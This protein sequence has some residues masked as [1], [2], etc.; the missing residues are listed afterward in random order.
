VRRRRPVEFE[1]FPAALPS[2]ATRNLKVSANIDFNTALVFK[3]SENFQPGCTEPTLGL[4]PS[5]GTV[6]PAPVTDSRAL[7][8]LHSL[9][10]SASGSGNALAHFDGRKLARPSG[11]IGRTPGQKLEMA[12]RLRPAKASAIVAATVQL[13]VAPQAALPKLAA[14]AG[15]TKISPRPRR[16]T[17]QPAGSGFALAP[18]NRPSCRS[19]PAAGTR[20][21]WHR[22]IATVP[23]NETDPASL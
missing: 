4:V 22:A 7:H 21:N 19:V 8:P 11:K 23:G 9:P 3:V 15:K 12:A 6:S 17:P 16:W 20:K 18:E 13:S 14:P 10:R 5:L 1:K 2:S